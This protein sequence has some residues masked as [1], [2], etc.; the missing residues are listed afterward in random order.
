MRIP[1]PEWLL[2]MSQ[3]EGF[4]KWVNALMVERRI[5]RKII[6]CD[7]CRIT[8]YPLTKELVARVYPKPEVIP[9]GKVT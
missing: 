1:I 4:I 8:G 2:H 5:D 9:A 6:L 7:W 3:L